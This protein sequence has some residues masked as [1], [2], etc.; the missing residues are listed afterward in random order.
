MEGQDQR[1]SEAEEVKPLSHS[2]R[3]KAVVYTANIL[4]V[5]EKKHLLKCIASAK[6]V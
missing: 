5:Q 2:F 4:N 1:L 3:H 6:I